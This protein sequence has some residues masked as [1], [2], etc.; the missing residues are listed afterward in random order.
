METIL[1]KSDKPHSF[2]CGK[3][4][5][6]HKIYYNSVDELVLHLEKLKNLGVYKDE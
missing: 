4:G 3:A 5:A 2:E 1:N 6:R